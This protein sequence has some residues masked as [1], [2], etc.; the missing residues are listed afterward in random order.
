MNS[1]FISYPGLHTS[2]SISHGFFT[3]NG[4][5]SEGIYSSLNCGLGSKDNVNHI[6]EN[7]KRVEK[8]LSPNSEKP[9]PLVTLKQIHSNICK[10]VHPN[11]NDK[12]GEGD[13]LATS[14]TGLILGI[15]TADCTPVLFFDPDNKVIGAAHAGWKGAKTGILSNTVSKM[16]ELGA[17]L[18][19]IQAIIGPTIHQESYEVGEEFFTAFLDDSTSNEAFFINSDK[20]SHYLFNLPGFVISC[21]K[22]TGINSI[23][24]LKRNTYTDKTDF[25]SWRRTF[26]EGLTDFGC[27]ASCITMHAD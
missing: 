26:H 24:D 20:S 15:L 4:G 5:V 9:Y 13:A 17:K 14:S 21:L 12:L 7:R 8:E 3:R 16:I 18:P 25:Y 22:D 1:M 27:Q 19:S 10:I 23:F 11:N 6:H 2:S